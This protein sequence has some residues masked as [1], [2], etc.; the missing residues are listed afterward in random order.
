M[1]PNLVFRHR[2]TGLNA[3]NQDVDRQQRR[4]HCFSTILGY[5]RMRSM[6]FTLATD[7]YTIIQCHLNAFDYFSGYT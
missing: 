5:S 3:G 6:E 4:L 1:R 7:V 2:S